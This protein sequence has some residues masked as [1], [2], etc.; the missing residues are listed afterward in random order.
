MRQTGLTLK[1]V[2]KVLLE[3]I[4]D[5]RQSTTIP[6]TLDDI[7]HEFADY[8]NFVNE[9]NGDDGPITGMLAPADSWIDSVD[10]DDRQT[11]YLSVRRLLQLKSVEEVY[12]WLLNFVW[13]QIIDKQDSFRRNFWKLE[14]SAVVADRMMEAYKIVCAQSNFFVDT[15]R[16]RPLHEYVEYIVNGELSVLDDAEDRVFNIFKVGIEKFVPGEISFY[17]LFHCNFSKSYWGTL[18]MFNEQKYSGVLF[19]GR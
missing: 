1:E 18:L 17:N 2:A 9:V 10:F 16:N 19:Y 14:S 13:H 7:T 12:D 4:T 6:M 8:E 11:Y 15:R 3:A 5:F